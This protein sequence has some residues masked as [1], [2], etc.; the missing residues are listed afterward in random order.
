[1]PDVRDGESRDD[2]MDR[3]MGDDKMNSEFGN[4]RQRAAVCNSYYDDKK[5]QNAEAAEYQGRK[6]TLNKPFR[7][8][9]GPKKFAVYVQNES[10]RVVIV[11]FGDPN[12]EIK[13]DDPERRRNFRSRHNCDNPGPR[14]KARYWSC[15]QW[16]SGRKVEASQ[17]KN[18]LLYD[19]WMQNEGEIMEGYEEIVEAGEDDCGCGGKTVEAKMIRRDVYDNPGEAMNRAKEM[20]LSGIHSHEED[21]K[22]V[23][24]PGK[25]HEEYRSKNSGRD[26]EPKMVSDKE[27]AYGM[28]EDDEKEKVA[29][30]HMD[31]EK[32]ASYHKD[33]KMA[34]YHK[35][36]EKMASYHKDDEDEEKK[37]KKRGMYAS[38]ECPVGEEMVNGTCKPVN[39]TMQATVESVSA[40]VEASTGKTVMEI[41]GIAFHE[42]FNKNKWALT[43]RGAEAAV[44]Q[45]FGADLTLN[46]PK[47]KAVGFERNTY[48]GVNEANVGIVASATMH[49]KGKEG[50]E[51]RYVAH[52]HRTELFEALESGMWLKADYGVSIGGFGIPISA[53]EKGMV[54]DMDFTFDHLAIVHKPAYPR[55]TIDSAKKIKKSMKE[56]LEKVEAGVNAGHGGQHG[57]PGPNDPRKTPAK[58][59]ERR[60]GSKRN[61]PGSARKPNRRIVVSP[62]TR[63]T[64]R[65]KMQKHNKAG[66][67]SRASMGALLTVFRRGAGAF[68]TSHAPNMS[69]NGWGIAR[70]NAFL[71]LLRNGRPSNPNYKQDNDLLPRGHP[72]AKRTA[73]AEETLI[74]QTAS[75]AEYRKENDIMSEE[76]IVEE[77]AHASEM[78]AIQAE[79]VLARA[80]LEEMRAMEAAKHEEARLSLVEA[81]TSLGMKGHEDLSSETLE[82]IIASWKES[83]PEPVVDMKPAEPAVA[84][85]ES[86]P[87]P[88]SEAVVANYL[89][90]KMVETPESLYAQAW[91]AWASAWNKTLSGVE[92][93]DERIRAPK[94]EQL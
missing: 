13:R 91:N 85:E 66:K 56:Q 80:E 32:M 28:P 50:Y 57:R 92:N 82:S 4:P 30:H 79:L 59:S 70:V 87:A 2:Y 21:G 47:P 7:T 29:Y 51:V 88:S 77:N 69:R 16:E 9:G 67:G 58:P 3:C 64:I 31:D 54:F 71:Y 52:V 44:K 34:S 74:S 40:T 41:K 53:N 46:H 90:G 89:N 8:P 20:G 27:A 63:T 81:A 36:K 11:R 5:G 39:V 78:E 42:G 76:Q 23:F 93:N 48:G 17:K 68:S 49:D 61:P 60:R 62:A 25:T 86:A 38:E 55:A 65:N 43:K 10:N 45:M 94:Y 14:T 18:Q 75:Q 12:M 73:S 1:M 19:E 15:R 83:H 6:V 72:R 22:T 84:S 35:D 33:E 37:K 26:V 24:M